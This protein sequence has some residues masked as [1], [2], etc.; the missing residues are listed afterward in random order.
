V[1]DGGGEGEDALQDA[2][3]DAL[4][5]MA[6][7]AFQ[8]ELALEG[9]VDG[10]D[11]LAQR[12]TVRQ[13]LA[14][15]VPA[16]RKRPA[17]RTS[18]LDPFKD[19][20]GTILHQEADNPDQPARTAKEIFDWLVAERGA[21]QVSC[22]T[23]RNYVAGRRTLRPRPRRTPPPP[24]SSASPASASQPRRSTPVTPSPAHLAVEHED[25]SRLRDLL[26][27]GHDVEDDNGDGWTLPL[28]AIDVET[29]IR[30]HWLAAEIMRARI[31]QGQGR[32]PPAR[33]PGHARLPQ[34]R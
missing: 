10:F 8:V 23:V 28:H 27:A 12:R 29:G 9:V 7:V 32:P 6:A 19:A 16:P 21:A 3:G 34:L 4:R 20:I 14:S 15:P 30:G 13:A 11:D 31:G 26:D 5:G 25:L 33:Q 17:E 1:P 22:S 24:P 2:D 18:K